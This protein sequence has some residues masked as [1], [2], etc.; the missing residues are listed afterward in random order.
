[1]DAATASPAEQFA[2]FPLRDL[3]PD[4]LDV[5]QLVH[6]FGSFQGAID[7]SEK[8]DLVVA[9]AIAKL[10]QKGYVRGG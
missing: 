7:H 9:E 2:P 4:E 3:Q 10:V 1:M 5:L 8:D 6:N